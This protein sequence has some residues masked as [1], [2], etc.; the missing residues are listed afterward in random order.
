VESLSIVAPMAGVYQVEVRGYTATQYHLTVGVTDSAMAGVTRTNNSQ[1]AST[2]TK[3][4]PTEPIVAPT[5][6]PGD[7][8]GMPGAPAISE[9]TKIY[10]PLI[11]K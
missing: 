11:I 6:I 10:L 9:G 5:N 3:P 8:V 4:A 7:Q 2:S 1:L